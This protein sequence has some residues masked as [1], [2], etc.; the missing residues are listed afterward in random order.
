MLWKTPHWN[1]MTY[2]PPI[3][4]RCG[5]SIKNVKSLIDNELI[6]FRQDWDNEI[7][8]VEAKI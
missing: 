8:K 7:K 3:F 4:W 6:R 1:K 2:F 5:I